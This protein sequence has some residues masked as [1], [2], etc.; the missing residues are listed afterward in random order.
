VI[1]HQTTSGTVSTQ[2]VTTDVGMTFEVA[3]DSSPAPGC[4][5]I[6]LFEAGKLRLHR[7]VH[8]PASSRGGKGVDVFVFEAMAPGETQVRLEQKRAW[9]TRPVRYETITVRVGDR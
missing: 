6:P 9:E 2:S 7:K 1:K 4:Q 3:V 8:M 5:W